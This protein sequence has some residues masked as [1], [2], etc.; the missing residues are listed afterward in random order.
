MGVS[1]GSSQDLLHAITFYKYAL[2]I[3]LEVHEDDEDSTEL[4]LLALYN[5]LGH[6]SIQLFHVDDAEYYIRCLRE[7]LG[8]DDGDDTFA[9]AAE[10]PMISDE[11]YELFCF[12]VALPVEFIVAPAA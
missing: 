11:D 12:N 5:N 6:A 9:G 10:L 8:M 7:E 3:L 4:L 2:R 1:R